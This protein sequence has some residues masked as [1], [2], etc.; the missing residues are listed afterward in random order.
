M[1]ANLWS[2][3]LDNPTSRPSPGKAFLERPLV[4]NTINSLLPT[5]I[6]PAELYRK[7]ISQLTTRLK[8]PEHRFTP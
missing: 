1:G 7:L 4:I 3:G 6:E 8:D 5:P 2:Q